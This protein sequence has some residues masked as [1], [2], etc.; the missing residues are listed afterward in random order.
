MPASDSVS[1]ADRAAAA[2]N[3]IEAERFL[4]EAAKE[5][6]ELTLFLKLA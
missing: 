6:P 2:G 3:L 4:T 1:Q 5:A